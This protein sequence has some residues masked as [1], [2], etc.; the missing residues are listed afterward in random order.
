MQILNIMNN[1]VLLV[2]IPILLFQQFPIP[3]FFQHGHLLDCYFVEFVQA[4][5]LRDALVDEH[6]VKILHIGE[7]NK[8]VD[9]GIVAHIAFR[10]GI[11]FTPLLGG[12]PEES[13]IEDIRFLGVDKRAMVGIHLV[14]Y[15]VGSHSVG[16]YMVC[17]PLRYRNIHW[18]F[19]H[20]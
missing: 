10:A 3:H 15:K 20:P 13:H 11:G 2:F 6:R 1:M 8:L 19:L 12:H 7:A 9:G 17:S 4:I 5:T 16:V 14:G 18:M